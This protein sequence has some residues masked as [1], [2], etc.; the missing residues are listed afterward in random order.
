PQAEA[1]FIHTLAPPLATLNGTC[2]LTTIV[3][4]TFDKEPVEP[5]VEPLAWIPLLGH[6]GAAK[7]IIH[8]GF[9]NNF[10]SELD[11]TL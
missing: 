2:R 8:T 7:G 5:F 4:K 6:E 11:T 10:T 9:K 1:F 3:R